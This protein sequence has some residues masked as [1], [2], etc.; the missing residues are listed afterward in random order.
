L[1]T[2]TFII[3][4]FFCKEL[5]LIGIGVNFQITKKNIYNN[6]LICKLGYSHKIIYKIPHD[7]ICKKKIRNGVKILSI[8]GKNKE[9]IGNI[10]AQIFNTKKPDNYKGKG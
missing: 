2:F 6:Y 8:I 5:K 3:I 7:I 9:R 10:A 4:W 1:S